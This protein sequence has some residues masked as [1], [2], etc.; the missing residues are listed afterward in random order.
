M[1]S[2]NS[3]GEYL[4]RM[5]EEN[6]KFR[7]LY[8]PRK[9]R[10]S[11]KRYNILRHA[12]TTVAL[13]QLFEATR[14]ARYLDSA[15]RAMD[16]LAQHIRVIPETNLAYVVDHD[17]KA[18][19]GGAAL[20]LLAYTYKLRL[21]P[22]TEQDREYAEKIARFILSMQSE[23]GEFDSYLA[24]PGIPDHGKSLYYPGEAM[25]AL[26][27]YYEIVRDPSLLEAVQ[28]GAAWLIADE[29]LMEE[30]PPDAWFMQ[31][32][33]AAYAHTKNAA[34][35]AHA[36]ALADAIIARQYGKDAP[37]GYEGGFGPGLPRST[38]ASARTEGLLGAYRLAVATQDTRADTIAAA[39]RASLRFQLTHQYARN[40]S[41]FPAPEKAEGGIRASAESP[42]IRIDYVQHHI[43]A[44]L[45]AVDAG[46][47]Q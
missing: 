10:F 27:R 19:L 22:P 21:F 26:V 12:G 2:V 44:V 3:G 13:Y 25:L 14:D 23:I 16:Y 7:Y 35:A 15:N 40:T 18:K 8:N 41:G 31:A 38:P 39:I 46:L 47:I 45:G 17:G 20:G 24:L 29:M 6:G 33:D 32:L 4:L 28:K 11:K 43:S 37:P 9:D 5:Q 42:S 30:L 1:A 34:Y 36:L